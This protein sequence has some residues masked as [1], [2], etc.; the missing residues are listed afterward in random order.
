MAD[1]RIHATGSRAMKDALPQI[2]S[3]LLSF[4][5][6]GA[7]LRTALT[8]I[9]RME[10]AVG[11]H[12]VRQTQNPTK[13]TDRLARQRAIFC[14]QDACH[15][16]NGA[17]LQHLIQKLRSADL[18]GTFDEIAIGVDPVGIEALATLTEWQALVAGLTI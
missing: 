15:V 4:R 16:I 8:G 12:P 6:L 11:A 14:H 18:F 5:I 3:R 7:F 2:R 1:D 17:G 10:I 13:L 9:F